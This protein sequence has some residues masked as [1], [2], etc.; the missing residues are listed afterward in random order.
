MY[1]ANLKI[2]LIESDD[3]YQNLYKNAIEKT[4]L[5]E[6]ITFSNDF[7]HAIKDFTVNYYDIIVMDISSSKKQGI[8]FLKNIRK[9]RKKILFIMLADRSDNDTFVDILQYRLIET[10]M[11]QDV[12]DFERSIQILKIQF[13]FIFN[14]YFKEKIYE[15]GDIYKEL[16]DDLKASIESSDNYDYEEME[17]EET[18]KIEDIEKV[19]FNKSNILEFKKIDFILIATSTGGPGALEKVLKNINMN[20]DVPVLV[21]QHMPSGFTKGLAENLDRKVKI[22][23]TEAEDGEIVERGVTYIARGGVHMEVKRDS[24]N[25]KIALIYDKPVNNVI[26]AADVL[27][28]SIAK[29]YKSAYILAIVL[30]GMGSDGKK[31]IVELK[32]NCNCYCITQSEDSCIV[33]GMPMAVY[34]EGLSDEVLDVELIGN[35]INEILKFRS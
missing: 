9:I 8:K 10:I 21:V 32:K 17:K 2:L 22:Y 3:E 16:K 30:T 34:E 14:Q 29:E 18:E 33:Y 23:V 13:S 19:N 26:P 5:I 24:E 28:E 35:R 31:G 15:E 20:I 1:L 6:N 25:C 27:F 11:K 12:K 7:E 4:E